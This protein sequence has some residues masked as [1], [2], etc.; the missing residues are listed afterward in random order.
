MVARLYG[1]DKERLDNEPCEPGDVVL[2]GC[3]LG[4]VAEQASAVRWECAIE[5][6]EEEGYLAGLSR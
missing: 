5:M 2:T 3:L 1:D 4:A 6:E